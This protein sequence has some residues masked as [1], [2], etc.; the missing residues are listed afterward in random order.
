M[1]TSSNPPS[2]VV[3]DVIFVW[4]PLA[5]LPNLTEPIFVY[6]SF[7]QISINMPN[8][9]AVN[10]KSV[11]TAMWWMSTPV[12]KDPSVVLFGS[13]NVFHIRKKTQMKHI[14]SPNN[15]HLTS[16]WFKVLYYFVELVYLSCCSIYCWTGSKQYVTVEVYGVDVLFPKQFSYTRIECACG[17]LGQIHLLS[18]INTNN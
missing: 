8:L 9:E 18:I 15:H 7:D 14:T 3:R 13:K 5:V 12:V 16:I 11:L 4:L 2:S 1:P 10:K 17:I 6:F